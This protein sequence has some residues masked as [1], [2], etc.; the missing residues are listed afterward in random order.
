V[1]I[2]IGDSYVSRFSPLAWLVLDDTLYGR[3]GKVLSN[4]LAFLWIILF[5]HV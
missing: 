3:K 2:Y 1:T 4:W 5:Q